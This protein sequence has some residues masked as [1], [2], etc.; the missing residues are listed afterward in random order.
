[1]RG[2]SRDS[3]RVRAASFGL[4]ATT[5]PL[6]PL[7]RRRPLNSLARYLGVGAPPE[8]AAGLMTTKAISAVVSAL[9]FVSR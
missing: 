6:T 9:W 5:A 3:E 8:L 1:M 4:H 7:A 2:V